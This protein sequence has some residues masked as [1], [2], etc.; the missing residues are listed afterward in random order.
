MALVEQYHMDLYFESAGMILT[1]IT[2]GKFLETRSK[3]KT[4]EAISRLMDLAPKTASVLRDGAEV[5]IPVEEVSGGRPGGGPTRPVHP[6]GRRH[7][8]G[9]AP[10]WTNPPSP[11]RSIPV[12]KVPGD[13]VAAASINKSGSFV[14][15]A[16]RVGE[17]TTLAQMI[18]LVE[19]A[20]AS[21][22]PI[23]KL[24]D[25]VAGSVRPSGHG[26]RRRR[27]RRLARRR[28]TALLRPS[29]PAWPCWSI[30]CPCALGLAT[31]VAIMVGTGQGRG[32]RHSDQIRRGAGDP[33]H[34]GH[35]GAGQDG[36]PH[37]GQA[38]GHRPASPAARWTRTA[39]LPW[40]PALEGPSEHPLASAIVERGPGAGAAP[41][42]A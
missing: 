17:D 42:P 38:R 36:H 13:K 8:G 35:R 20:S 33:A 16:S 27:R 32:K 15:E 14:F 9:A 18:R 10:P 30:S 28:A 31:P 7:Y 21:K 40:P 23:A 11:A 2:L 22:A 12:D 24:A 26:H 4:G 39:C 1:L 41:C 25:R 37:P 5:E 19:E 3:G 34:R 6:R 29:P